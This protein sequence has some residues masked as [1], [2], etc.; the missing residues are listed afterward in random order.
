MYYNMAVYYNMALYYNM[1]MHYNMAVH[2]NMAKY[3]CCS[4]LFNLAAV[5]GTK[6]RVTK[7]IAN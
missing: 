7:I 4:T 2:Y 5:W 3:L 6:L 1:A